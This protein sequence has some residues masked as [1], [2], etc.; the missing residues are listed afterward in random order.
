MQQKI[1]RSSVPAGLFVTSINQLIDVK[2]RNAILR[3]QVDVPEIV[4]LGLLL[5]AAL[6]IGMD[7]EMV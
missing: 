5:F 2:K 3:F 4:L 1:I 7:T 6:A